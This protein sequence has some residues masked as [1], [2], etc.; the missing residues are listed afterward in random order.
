VVIPVRNEERYL[1]HCLDAVL[2]QDY[3]SD[4][5][6]IIVVDGCST[7]STPEIVLDLA[8]AHPRLKLLQQAAASIPRQLNQGIRAARGSIIVRID[9]HTVVAPDYVSQCVSALETSGADNVGGLAHNKSDGF[10]GEAI[11]RATSS[12]FGRPGKFHRADQPQD[13]ETV[14]LGAFRRE[15]LERVGLFDESLVA[16]EDFELNYRIRRAGGRIHYTP[17]I[18]REYYTRDSLAALAK[19]Y[20]SYGRAKSV[21]LKQHPDSALPRHFAAPLFVLALAG[22]MG[23]AAFWRPMPLLVLLGLYGSAS[24]CFSER[25]TQEAGARMTGAVAL[26]FACMHLSWGAGMLAELL[27]L[28]RANRGSESWSASVEGSPDRA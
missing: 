9:G 18:R 28:G 27:G 10:W 25:A 26:A 16:N 5:L 12:P 19:Q 6:E 2:A 3:P 4:R 21:V 1:R 23:L 22:G 13:V 7:D 24:A 17:L 11:A 8:D 14:F 20:W 15:T